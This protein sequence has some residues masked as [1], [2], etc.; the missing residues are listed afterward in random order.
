M[1]ARP[2]YIDAPAEAVRMSMLGQFQ[3]DLD[4]PPEPHPDFVT[5]HRYAANFPWQSHAVWFMTQMVRWGQ[6]TEQKPDAWYAETAEKIYRPDVYRE[7][8]AMLVAEGKATASDFPD[9][10]TDGYRP[11]TTP[12]RTL[13]ALRGT[14]P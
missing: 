4:Q 12:R 3:F 9:E 10:G 6:I 2:G 1:I 7:A 11:E 8:A 14:A 13:A 5:F